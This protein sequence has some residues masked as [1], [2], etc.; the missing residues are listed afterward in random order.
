MSTSTIEVDL[1]AIAHNT[2]LIAGLVGPEAS[3]CAV[4][5]ADGYGLGGARIAK[6]VAAVLGEQKGH[7]I[8][9][10][11]LDQAREVVEAA[12]RIP[13]L[14]LMPIREL[15]RDDRL[16]RFAATG[17]LHFTAHDT[18]NLE[19]IAGIAD[20]LGVG[21]DVHVEV[22]TGMARGGASD[23]E[24]ARMVAFCDSHRRLRLAGLYT[25]LS[26]AESDGERTGEQRRRFDA[27]LRGVAPLTPADC[28]IHIANTHGVFR[29]R[30][31]HRS[32]VRVGLGLLGYA[33]RVTHEEGF[34]LA[35]EAQGLRPALRW[36][37]KLAHVRTISSGTS[38]GYGSTWA[39]RRTSRIGLL[40][41]GYADG[42]PLQLSNT[43]RVGVVLQG[44][45]RAYVP[46]VGAVSMDQT[47]IDI[48]D[49]PEA[50]LG[51]E[52]ELIGSESGTPNALPAVA[53]A[54]GTIPYDVLCRLHAHIERRYVTPVIRSRGIRPASNSPGT[55]L[56]R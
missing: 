17:K 28:R 26:S 11:T 38:V 29:G 7:M 8:G 42:Y 13:I 24:A 36:T 49:V 30:E 53:R 56:A 3:V 14:V 19:A 32:M 18:D 12:I 20:T 21:I 1:D 51:T 39:A 10:Y 6:R 43:G 4:L 45:I 52:V 16:Y 44:G 15:R 33:D 23:E 25:H 22:D 55:L 46:V 34:A 9:V 5:K 47:V 54:A 27:F 2:E 50:G 48:T 37:T 35:T 31:H 41:V 40:P